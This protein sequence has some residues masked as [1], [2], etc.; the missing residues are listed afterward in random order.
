M[1]SVLRVLIGSDS[2]VNRRKQNNRLTQMTNEIGA[3]ILRFSSDAETISLL[4]GEYLIRQDALLDAVY[5]VVSGRLQAILEEE[6]KEDRVV[7]IIGPD[8]TVGE[9]S[10]I[11]HKKTLTSVR[12][13]HDTVLKKFSKDRFKELLDQNR[14]IEM[15][16]MNE[17]VDRLQKTVRAKNYRNKPKTIVVI[18]A[19]G[20]LTCYLRFAQR[21]T[22]IL[23]ERGKAIFID[24]IETTNYSENFEKI[25][26]ENEFVVL[27]LSLEPDDWSRRYL[28]EA[29]HVYLVAD[30]QS[31]FNLNSVE[32]EIN[33]ENLLAS[34]ETVELVLVHPSATRVAK[35]TSLWLELRKTSGYHH[36]R[37]EE[38]D[39]FKRVIRF[40]LGE[41][42]AVVLGGGGAK[43]MA[44][45]GVLRALRECKIPIDMIAGTSAGSFVGALCA[46]GFTSD[47]QLDFGRRLS[48]DYKLKKYTLP[49]ISLIDTREY[50]K[51]LN[52][53][54]QDYGVEDLF[55]RYFCVSC[56]LNHA[57]KVIHDR[58][59]IRDAVRA[60]TSV[61]GLFAPFLYRNELLI[62]GGVMDN[63][64][65][66]EVR[67]RGASIIIAV[68]VVPASDLKISENI[69]SM[70]SGW[71]LLWQKLKRSGKFLALPNIGEI[72]MRTLM[73]NSVNRRAESESFA[74][75][76]LYPPLD[77]IKMLDFSKLES[78]A[79][80]GYDHALPI[81]TEFKA[82]SDLNKS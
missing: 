22:E 72:L 39:D 10:L 7:A 76:I 51:A 45:F 66:E 67:K 42:V 79:K 21:L 48:Q 23:S 8:E 3:L 31:P 50:E 5:L 75:L 54:F 47:E 2:I 17:L 40:L 81:L 73:L 41:Q 64:P 20:D 1:S 71:S 32:E 37:L 53:F 57:K 74:D 70:P 26:E 30:S 49:W 6:N 56:N 27:S 19:G 28:A 13:L 62:D 4:E 44:H 25:K 82:K 18:P 77:N 35:G 65:V 80:L 59:L 78:V 16:L 63:L 52:D 58:N 9:L 36:L 46:M 29:D 69:E 14:S 33:Q 34:V 24:S 61:P 43:G 15:A 68:D 55:I 38:Y 11:S 60:S 12:A